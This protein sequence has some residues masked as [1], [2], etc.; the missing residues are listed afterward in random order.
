M[1][2]GIQ[3]QALGD[4]DP[5]ALQA[6]VPMRDGVELAT[7]VYLP[8]GPDSVTSHPTIL[9]R[10]PYDKNDRFCFM[11]DVAVRLMEH[12]YAVVVQDV[13]GKARSQGETVAFIHE[14]DDGY[15]TLEWITQQPWSNGDVGSFGDSYYGFTQWAMIASGH[16][17]L[18]AAVP[19]MTT[20]EIAE[21]WMY[22]R[23]VFNLGTMGEWALHAW[24][25]N[26]LNV[27]SIDW[28]TRPLSAL[29]EEHTGGR[30]SASY[31]RWIA[32]PADSPYWV[33]D[34]YAGHEVV[35]GRIPTLHVGGFFDVFS[36]GQLS[37]FAA[38]LTGP[39]GTDQYLNMGA[40][41]HFDDIVTPSGKSPDHIADD[42]VLPAF[43]DRYL[44][45]ALEFFDRYLKG[46]SRTIPRVRWEAAHGDW[47]EGDTW[48]PQGTSPLVLHLAPSG[49]VAT[50][51]R[52]GALALQAPNL[53]AELRWTHEPSSPVPS[54]VADPWRPLLDLPDE[55]PVD[56]RADVLTFTSGE[57][58]D[59]LLLAGP[60]TVRLTITADAP[61]THVVARLCDVRPDG[62]SSLI[63][64]GVVRVEAP[65]SGADAAIDLGDTG[66]LVRSGHRLRLQVSASSF[67]RWPVHPGT[68]EDPLHARSGRHVDHMLH[69]GKNHE[70]TVTLTVLPAHGQPA[71][72]RDAVGSDQ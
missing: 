42:S 49:H 58:P 48:P 19:R 37:D 43:L 40:T 31:S 11:A 60:V 23:G 56:S 65:D 55:R 35:R 27:P 66:Y 44:E 51:P 3:P 18:K 69:L 67:P 32:E 7:D 45:P 72:S 30:S 28:N 52:G 29:I 39:T 24:V 64:E 70:G 5:R 1:K 9:V 20:T 63:V 12:G 71:P 50:D 4:P 10:L 14:V 68:D 13:R 36:R 8:D 34:V 6:A 38:S 16:P 62:R 47:H 41:D 17:A 59:G 46:S 21:D 15:D 53:S 33:K 54:L 2:A 22:Q 61:S 57:W 25:D 26:L